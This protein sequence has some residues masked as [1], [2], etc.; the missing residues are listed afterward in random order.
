MPEPEP[1][2]AEELGAAG[3]PGKVQKH[4]G[5]EDVG[6]GVGHEAEQTHQPVYHLLLVSIVSALLLRQIIC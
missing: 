1:G 4:Q 5:P 2:A 3:R 6:A